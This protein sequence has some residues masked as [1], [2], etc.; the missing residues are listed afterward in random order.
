MFGLKQIAR[1]LEG[2]KERYVPISVSELA[3][4]LGISHSSAKR[5]VAEAVRS[6]IGEAK[7]GTVIIDKV[8]LDILLSI[9]EGRY[10][11]GLRLLLMELE[12]M[13]KIRRLKEI[14]V[15]DPDGVLY[16]IGLKDTS[17]TGAIADRVR[18][19]LR[20]DMSVIIIGVPSHLESDVYLILSNA[21]PLR[22]KVVSLPTPKMK[23]LL[24]EIEV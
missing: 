1:V 18:E 15:K 8:K 24:F 3:R 19:L 23:A 14:H 12:R 17:N 22:G 5:Y 13:G 20:E 16:I 4:T 10:L 6:H 21:T 9:Y 2:R 11:D 7:D